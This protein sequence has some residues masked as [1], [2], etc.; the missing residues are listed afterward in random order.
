[1]PAAPVGAE[2]VLQSGLRMNVCCIR[3]FRFSAYACGDSQQFEV[4]HI[5]DYDRISPVMTEPVP[6]ACHSCCRIQ[7]CRQL[8][9]GR[10]ICR[11]DCGRIPCQTKGVAITAVYLETYVVVCMHI[12]QSFQTAC[13][14]P[15]ESAEGLVTCIFIDIP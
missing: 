15:C 7:T 14:L 4:H 6:A 11:N 12:D 2:M 5:V 9:C 3:Q 8:A 10:D 13:M 1:M